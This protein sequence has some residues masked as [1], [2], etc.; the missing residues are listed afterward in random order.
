MRHVRLQHRAKE[1]VVALR[2]L[3]WLCGRRPGDAALISRLGYV[4]L[5]IGDLKA[6]AQTFQQARSHCPPLLCCF[7]APFP[8]ARAPVSFPR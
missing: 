2:W 7:T 3:A 1:H 8:P 5:C 6:A 4:Q